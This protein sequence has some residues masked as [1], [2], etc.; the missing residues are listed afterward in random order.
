[1]TATLPDHVRT[2]LFN[3]V[4]EVTFAFWV[5]KIGKSFNW[6]EVFRAFTALFWWQI[7]ASTA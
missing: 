5:I 4:P 3:R 2:I 6:H 1:M 7:I